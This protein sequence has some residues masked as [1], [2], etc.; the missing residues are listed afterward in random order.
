MEAERN[1]RIGRG[2]KLRD[3]EQ[4]GMIEPLKGTEENPLKDGLID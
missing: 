4:Q 3:K 2:E 1:K